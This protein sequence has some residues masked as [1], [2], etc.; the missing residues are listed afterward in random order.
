[1]LRWAEGSGIVRLMIH[2]TK[3]EQWVV[4]IL[5]ALLLTGW[6]VKS[7]RTAHPPKASIQP[8]NP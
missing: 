5:A 6:L 4:C 7:Y 1:M 8:A 3:Q 2:L